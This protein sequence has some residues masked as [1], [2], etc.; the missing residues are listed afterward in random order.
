MK[1]NKILIE[2]FIDENDED[3][4]LDII[5]FVSTPAIEKNFMHFNKKNGQYSFKS[6]DDEKRIVTG[7]AMVPNQEIIR[8]DAENNAYFVYFTEETIIKSQ[9]IFAKNGKTKSTNFEHQEGDM[10]GVTVVESWIVTDPKN[11]KSNALGFT[12]IPKGTW[13]VSYKVD[14]DELWSKVKSGEVQ[15]FSIEGVFSKNII[16]MKSKDNDTSFK[17]IQDI[18]SIEGISDDEIFDK[19]S[20]ILSK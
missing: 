6:T 15:G 13:M 10:K 16:Q 3:N 9:E 4:A 7:P 19:V 14:N 11:D 17:E 2:L 8:M 5:S 20:K 1:N 12:S 18:L